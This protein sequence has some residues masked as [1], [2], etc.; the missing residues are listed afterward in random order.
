MI[1]LDTDA[2]T[3]DAGRSSDT[4]GDDFR[5]VDVARDKSFRC[6]FITY[7]YNGREH[8]GLDATIYKRSKDEGRY[9]LPPAAREAIME[10][11]IKFREEHGLLPWPEIGDPIPKAERKELKKREDPEQLHEARE[12]KKHEGA[13]VAT[14]AHPPLEIPPQLRDFDFRFIKLRNPGEVYHDRDGKQI[15]A[16]GKEAKETGW[17][18][19]NNYAWN[20]PELVKWL[21]AG[22]N[23]GVMGSDG[24]KILD[25]DSPEMEEAIGR[26]PSTFTVRTGGGGLH[27][28]FRCGELPE[29]F[30]KAIHDPVRK[31]ENGKPYHYGDIQRKGHYVVGPGSLHHTGRRYD[32]ECTGWLNEIA[33]EDIIEAFDDFLTPPPEEAGEVKAQRPEGDWAWLDALRIEAVID[34]REFRGKKG[35]WQTGVNPWHGSTKGDAGTNLGVNT[36]ENRAYCRRCW[37]NIFP[38]TAL[39]LKHGI[40]K[41]CTDTPKGDN[42]HKAVDIAVRDYGIV[43]PIVAPPPVVVDLQRGGGNIESGMDLFEINKKGAIMGVR[44]LNVARFILTRVPMVTMRDNDEILYYDNGYYRRGGERVVEDMAQAL[45]GEYAGNHDV[46]EIV[47]AVKRDTHRDREELDTDRKWYCMENGHLNVLEK[48]LYPASP[49][50]LVT[51]RLPFPFIEG[52]E[53]TKTDAFI[54]RALTPHNIEDPGEAAKIL[55]Q[56]VD[57]FYEVVGYTFDPQKRLQKA[58]LF[59]GPPGTS[60]GAATR[61]MINCLGQKNVSAWPLESL[62][63]DKFASGSIY[64]K[65]ANICAE[66][67][68]A[69]TLNSTVITRWISNEPVPFESKNVQGWSE[70]PNVNF[71]YSC[72]DTPTTS[73]GAGFYRRWNMLPF[74]NVVP[75]GERDDNVV[76]ELL[77]KEEAAGVLNRALDGL[78]RIIKN[79]SYTGALTAD[80]AEELYDALSDSAGRFFRSECEVKERDHCGEGG[81]E[82]W[83]KYYVPSDE[84]YNAYRKW[85]KRAGLGEFPKRRFISAVIQ[86]SG[87]NVYEAK[88]NTTDNGERINKMAVWN[89][90]CASI[91]SRNVTVYPKH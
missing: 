65:M 18:D 66:M 17:Q 69:K 3:P 14:A 88:V 30:P 27:A 77:T 79:N 24:L 56:R 44:Y 35:G 59:Y 82:T 87:G 70:P 25:A 83:T 12:V 39:A 85:C 45:L 91:R 53:P 40:I 22:N 81:L 86:A 80:E 72:N 5:I 11:G 34:T 33:W 60:K 31:N 41:N 67:D 48:K 32:V 49:E 54:E 76:Q 1:R 8:T 23:Y 42:W 2:T 43:R 10:A 78:Q 89:V 63:K 68:S 75:E 6:P 16:T 52:A 9:Y 46:R 73:G 61:I 84:L 47:G 51:K 15:I 38:L 13:K 58:T 26:L 28:Y 62:A 20:D 50:R 7:H 57:N 55:R 74:L 64:G 37:T 90:A 4:A 36:S 21:A 71:I 29:R 19:S